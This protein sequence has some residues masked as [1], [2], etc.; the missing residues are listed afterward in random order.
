MFGRF[1]VHLGTQ[2]GVMLGSK[3]AQ[4][5]PQTPPKTR[6]GARRRP[7]A[8]VR[9]LRDGGDD[10]G[11]RLQLTRAIPEAQQNVLHR[12]APALSGALMSKLGI[13]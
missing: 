12:F 10:P 13:R 4:R 2:V 9:R 8:E 11:P 1:R 3:M 5:P 6:L 7:R